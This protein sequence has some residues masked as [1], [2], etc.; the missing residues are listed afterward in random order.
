MA[1]LTAK[2]NVLYLFSMSEAT[3]PRDAHHLEIIG[4]MT[5]CAYELGIAAGEIAKRATDDTARFLAATAEFGRCF[6]AVRMGIRLSMALQSGASAP[7]GAAPAERLERE[8]PEAADPE[9]REERIE[10][11]REREG[12]YEP[13][14]LP[15]FLKTLGLAAARADEL[16]DELPA[17][18]RDTTLPTLHSLLR[19]ANAPP[20]ARR[21]APAVAILA[22]PV[23]VLAGR[24]HLLTSTGA[25]GLPP[26]RPIPIRRRDSG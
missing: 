3:V 16:R 24:S 12:D 14:S 15:R 13:V 1:R 5:Q 2:A 4:A 8:R 9:E 11:E 17:H 26:L 18:I 19:Q 23:A 6:F 7:R 10:T 21:T 25:I 20:G 22:P